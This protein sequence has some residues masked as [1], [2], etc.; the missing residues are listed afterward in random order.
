MFPQPARHF[1]KLVVVQVKFSQVRNVGQRAIFNSKDSVE[2]QSQ[3]A[4]AKRKQ[5]QTAHMDAFSQARD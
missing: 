3:P 2:A 1:E 4:T 5:G